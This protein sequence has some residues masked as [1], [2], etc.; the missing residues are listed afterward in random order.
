MISS[1]TRYSLIQFLDLQYDVFVITLLR[2]HG[3]RMNAPFRQGELLDALDINLPLRGNQEVLLSLIEEIV[4]TS[5]DLRARVNP[6]YR[7]DERFDDLCR[8]LQLDGYLIKGRQLIQIDPSINDAP[9]LDD[10]LL[11]ELK[12]SSLPEVDNIIRKIDDSS[13]AFTAASPNYNACLND[14]RI[15]LETLARSIAHNRESA[16]SPPYD[17]TKWGSIIAFLRVI[18]FITL[19][20]K[21]EASLVFMDL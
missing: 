6:R 16:S 9:R 20:G 8:C 13:S 19:R 2:K 1:R 12:S 4:R 15:A 7:F 10:D 18:G 5:G 3:L 17:P 14:I 11:K 21:N